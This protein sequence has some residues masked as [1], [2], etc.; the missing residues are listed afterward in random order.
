MEEKW[1]ACLATLEGHS[2]SVSS[3]AFLGDGR[4][5]ASASGDG[6]VKLWDAATGQC[7]AT[8]EGHS[9]YVSS[10]AFSGDGRRLA[11]AS[12]DNTVKLWDAAIGQCLQTFDVGRALATVSFDAT[13][14]C[15]YTDAG[16]LLLG[17]PSATTSTSR[18]TASLQP[19]F[20]GY[21]FSAGNAWIT[22]NGRNLLW[23][24][25]EYRPTESA[26][27]GPT[28][29]LGCASGRVLLLR[30][31]GDDVFLRDGGGM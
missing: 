16:K 20:Q 7:V 13:G 29:A 31:S 18:Q 1:N 11:S 24:P 30:F 27:A 9:G 19:Y 10:V 14:S 12:D 25:P 17:E 5:L 4:Q 22:W 26:V 21:G 28:V 2:G 6:T 23:L 15:L 3:V 8:L